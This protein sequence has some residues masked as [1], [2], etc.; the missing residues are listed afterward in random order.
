MRES[1]CEF[2]SNAKVHQ[3]CCQWGKTDVPL[4]QCSN[5]AE[6]ITHVAT[7]LCCESF[8][9]LDCLMI[10]LLNLWSRTL[11]GMPKNT[12]QRTMLFNAKVTILFHVYSIS[13]RFWNLQDNC[14]FY[15]NFFR[16]IWEIGG[17]MSWNWCLAESLV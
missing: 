1:K 17:Q 3:P 13:A 6:S 11:S 15:Q 8:L 16:T 2:S 10:S 5:P 12:G 4:S 9:K 7:R 14:Q